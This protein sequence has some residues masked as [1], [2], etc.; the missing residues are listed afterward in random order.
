MEQVQ[1]GT[2]PVEEI[3]PSQPKPVFESVVSVSIPVVKPARRWNGLEALS[4]R[5]R[6]YDVAAWLFVLA[7]AIYLLTRLIGL[8]QFPI[9][10]FTDEA[11]QSQSIIDLINNNYRDPSGVLLP[12]Y[13]RNGDY[14]NIGLSVYLQW[15]PAV[16]FGKS[17]VATRATSVLVTLIAAISIGILL[18]DVFKL[19]YWWTGTLFLSITPAWFLHSRTAFETVEFVAFYAGMLCAY[20][21][22]QQKS[23]LYLYLAVLLGALSFYSY[24]PAQVIIPADGAGLTA[25]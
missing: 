25:F 17:A 22:Y 11:I 18:R 16:L 1:R 23:S 14:Y 20:L 5:L 24:S 10:F 12:T 8:T 2:S 4:S 7:I 9:Y 19:K 13:F 21:F 3:S 6:A 15:L